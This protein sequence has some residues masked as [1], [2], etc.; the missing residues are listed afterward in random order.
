MVLPHETVAASRRLRTLL[1]ALSLVSLVSISPSFFR[2]VHAA[3]LVYVNHPT[4]A[5]DS[6][7]TVVTVQVQ[8]AGGESFTGWDIQVQ[9]NQSVITPIS[10]SIKGNAL[11]ANYSEKVLETVSCIN[12]VNYTTSHCDSSD[13]P[14]IVH[15]AA[16]ALQ[17]YPPTSLVYGLL[18]TIN[19]TVIRSG[20]YSPLQILR[21][22]ITNNQNPVSVTTRDGTYGIP[23][24]QGFSLTVSPDSPRIV[25]G[26][27]ANVTLTVSSYGGY[28]GTIDLTLGTQHLGL[29]LSLNPS[30]T[31]LSPNHPSNVTLTIATDTSYQASQYTVMVTATSNGVSHT[32][33]VSI[34]TTDKPD[35]ILDASPLVL[36]IHATTSGSSVI[37]LHTQSSFSGPIR[38]SLTVPDVPGLMASLGSRSLMISPGSPATTALDI[39]TPDSPIPFVYRVNI[40]ATSQSST[41]TLTI[42]VIPPQPDFS[43]LLS[44]AGHVIQAGESRT[45]T[46]TMTSIDYF[47]GQLYFFASSRFGFEEEFSPN[48]IGLDFGKTLTSTMTLT[49]D[50]NSQP[51]NHNVTL[52]ALST[53]SSGASV[54]H[55]IVLT[56]TITQIPFSNTILGLQSLTYFG[57]IGA[58]CLVPIIAIIRKVWKLKHGRLLS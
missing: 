14:G 32:A 27:K 11:E 57:I 45:F 37:T 22:V 58:L 26:S 20:S 56:V 18:F 10:L 54:T 12:G 41:H 24:G 1:I 4:T 9:T 43:F 2:F 13:G 42:V 3:G 7:A 29:L 40:T 36:E 52:T 51:G 46:L 25:I 31:P 53:P 47:K 15:S 30:S 50:T 33:T 28:S 49:T 23:L 34:S 17:G 19:Y 35:F 16:M 5:A 21:A 39:H 6:A 48:A 55:V 44:G 8:V 38:L